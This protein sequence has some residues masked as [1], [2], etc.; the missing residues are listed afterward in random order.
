MHVGHIN[1]A[2]AFNGVGE[3]FVR[4]IEELKLHGVEQRRV[5]RDRKSVV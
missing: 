2:E 4:L 3:H 5:V 1:L